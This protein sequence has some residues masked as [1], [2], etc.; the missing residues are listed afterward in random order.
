MYKLMSNNTRMRQLLE[1]LVQD[2]RFGGRTLRKAPGFSAT[3]VLTVAL[4]TGATTAIFSIVNS[5]LLRPLP[6]AAPDRL[7]QVEEMMPIGGAGAVLYPDLEEFRKQSSTFEMFSGYGLTTRHLQGAAGT[8]R[9]TAVVSDRYFFTLLGVQP[10][11]GRTFQSGDEGPAVVI[12]ERLWNRRFDRDPSVIGRTIALDGN[13]FDAARQRTVIE[14]RAYT[15]LGVMPETFQFPYGAASVYPAALPET[16]TDIWILDDRA[17][18]MGRASVTGRLKSG[19]MIDAAASE[20]S[21]IE[22]RL[23]VLTPSPY[24]PTGVRLVALAEDVLRSIRRFL[25]MLFGAVGLVLAAACANV[26]NLLLARTTARTREVVT[27]AALGAGRLRLARQFLTESLLLSFGGGLVGVAIAWWGTDLLVALGSAKIPRAHEI[28]PILD[29]GAFTFLLLVCVATAILFGL[30]PALTAARADIQTVTK[31]AAGHVTLGGSYRRIRDGLVVAEVALAFVLACGAVVVMRELSRLQQTDT[32]MVTDNVLTFHLTPRVEDSDY[33]KIEERVAQLPGVEAAGLI[34]MVPLQNWGGIGTFQVRGRPREEVA[35]LPTAELRSVTP[36][37]FQ[38]L[39]IPIRAG[40]PLTE[41]DSLDA[42]GAILVN[43]AL[44]RLHFAGED[45][46]GREMDRGRIVGV[47][48]DVR[49]VRLDRP[50]ATQIYFPVARTAGIASDIGMSLIVRAQGQ[51]QAVIDAVRSAVRQLNPNLAIF[52][53]RTMEQVLADS[54]WE[55]N[56][57]RWL[58]GLFA[59]LAL[60]LAGIGLY[61]VI[62]Y[63]VAS[64]TREFAIRLALGSDQIALARLVVSRGVRLAAVGLMVGAVAALALTRLVGNLTASLGPDPTTLAATSVLLLAIALLA[65]LVPAMRVARMDP[66]T[67]LRH[68]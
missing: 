51:P 40:R 7:V 63:S 43:E 44:A 36:G 38:A 50:A 4:A 45:P 47:V 19:V 12:S 16:Q 66:A 3:A 65:C 58:I 22:Q 13:T 1:D 30:A 48:A 31:E 41:R 39:G 67:A 25:W 42:P 37:Y 55:L 9:L 8:E 6:F 59:A 56:L 57:Y 27:R 15:V 11:A 5:V 35:R 52:N 20:L 10:I 23:D 60:V 61:G 18:R 21:L 17:R 64:R 2:V 54:L 29:W 33:Y 32:G 28:A 26:A 62:S 24:R 53:I 34:H 14:R 68:D 46:I 49:Q